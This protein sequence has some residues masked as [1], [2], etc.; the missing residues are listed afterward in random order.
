ME[1]KGKEY[2]FPQEAIV[3]SSKLI[4]T[5]IYQFIYMFETNKKSNKIS[6]MYK[7]MYK[8]IRNV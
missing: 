8:D 5:R 7:E 1:A 2:F 3:A 4:N 6:E